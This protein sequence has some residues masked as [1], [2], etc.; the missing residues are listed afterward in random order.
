[1][2]ATAKKALVPL[3]LCATVTAVAGAQQKGKECEVDEGKPGEVARAMLALQVAQSSPKPEDAAKQLKS[4]IAS[5]E[6]ADRSKNPVG[7]SFVLGK[8]LVM[9]MSQPNTRASC[10]RCRSPAAR[11]PRCRWRLT[12]TPQR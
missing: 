3:L 8:T 7:E 6:K 4:A 5:L 11:A 9:W 12:S 2:L 1:M 10:H